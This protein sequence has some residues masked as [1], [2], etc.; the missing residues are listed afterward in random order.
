MN[1]ATVL[2]TLTVFSVIALGLYLDR[3]KDKKS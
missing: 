1:I 2:V 3:K